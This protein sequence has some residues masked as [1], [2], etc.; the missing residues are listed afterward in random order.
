MNINNNKKKSRP[1]NNWQ[2]IFEQEQT[3]K[4]EIE[5]CVQIHRQRRPNLQKINK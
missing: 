3:N 5:K 2:E 1:I 4:E